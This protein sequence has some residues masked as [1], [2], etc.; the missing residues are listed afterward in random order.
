MNG[1]ICINA[2]QLVFQNAC[3]LLYVACR[4][5]SQCGRVAAVKMVGKYVVHLFS[6]C[7]PTAPTALFTSVVAADGRRTVSVYK[8]QLVRWI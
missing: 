3:Y 7:Q 6:H 4:F 2:D 1:H 8:F 5:N